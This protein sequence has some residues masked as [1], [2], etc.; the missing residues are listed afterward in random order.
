MDVRLIQVV[1]ENL[2]VVV[3]DQTNILEFIAHDGLLSKFYEE[4]LG[5]NTSNRWIGRIAR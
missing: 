2:L 3:R 1:G 5:L 4:G